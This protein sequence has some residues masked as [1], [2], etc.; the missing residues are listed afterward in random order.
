MT[1]ARN[2]PVGPAIAAGDIPKPEGL[3]DLLAKI[4]RISSIERGGAEL[5]DGYVTVKQ[6]IDFFT[7]G[8][9]IGFISSFFMGLLMPLAL[10]VA[11]GKIPIFGAVD[12]SVF[13]KAYILIFAASISLSYAFIIGTSLKGCGPPQATKNLIGQFLGGFNSG[14]VLKCLVLFAAF[15]ALYFSFPEERIFDVFSKLANGPGR[16]AWIFERIDALYTLTVALRSVLIESAYTA[17]ATGSV[18]ITVVYAYVLLGRR[19]LK[20]RKAFDY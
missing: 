10:S 2:S 19:R 14:I 1:A 11:L 9:K 12:Q 5:P 17:L 4:Q 20:R 6:K 16:N 8:F 7:A 15:H 13:D 3:I 18:S